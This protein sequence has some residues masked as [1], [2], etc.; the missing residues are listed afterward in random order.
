M[1]DRAIEL[2]STDCRVQ[3]RK[4]SGAVERQTEH[5]TATMMVVRP[6]KIDPAQ[7]ARVMLVAPACAT[8]PWKMN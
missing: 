3:F 1:P 6:R 2:C 4:R 8:A 5:T 7:I